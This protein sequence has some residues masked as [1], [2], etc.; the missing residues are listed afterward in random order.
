MKPLVGRGLL[1]PRGTAEALWEL[2][3]ESCD[4]MWWS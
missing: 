4:G 1:L 2:L 3:L